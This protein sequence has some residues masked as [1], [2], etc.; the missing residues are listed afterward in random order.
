V[1][2][3]AARLHDARG[4]RERGGRAGRAAAGAVTGTRAPEPWPRRGSSPGPD[5]EILRVR[6]DHVRN[7]RTGE[8]LDRVVLEAPD[9]VNVVALTHAHELVLVHQYRFGA[10]AIELEI[11]AG[12]VEGGEPHRDAA[13]RE[14][15]EETGYTATRW[16]Y[17]GASAPN[18]AFLDN[19]CHHW[20]AEEAVET[21]AQ[22]L[23]PGED[24]AV[25][26]RPLGDVPRL[27]FEGRVRN[28][29]VVSALARIVDLR[30]C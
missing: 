29:M 4:R 8:A 21:A 7:P 26:L 16:S 6:I 2:S 12:I 23:D 11:P 20:L 24:I 27:V 18:P 15:A 13:I 3:I 10:G 17:L 1:V 22:T 30:S 5:L 28:A 25:E 19:V 9:W 14:L